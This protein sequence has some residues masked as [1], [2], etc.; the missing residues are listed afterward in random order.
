M[1]SHKQQTCE[2]LNSHLPAPSEVHT[3]APHLPEHSQY[4]VYC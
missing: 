1:Q 3:R 2:G 4:V